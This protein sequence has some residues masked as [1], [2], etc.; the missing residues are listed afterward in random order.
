[1]WV[2]GFWE[3]LTKSRRRQVSSVSIVSSPDS[4]VVR[5]IDSLIVATANVFDVPR[6]DDL[7]V[8][9]W[10]VVGSA[11]TVLGNLQRFRIFMTMTA[12]S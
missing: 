9:M 1:M 11:D 2:W 6:S 12:T 10:L 5:G 4:G 3:A 8:V 7:T